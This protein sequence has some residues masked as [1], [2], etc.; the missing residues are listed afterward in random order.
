MRWLKKNGGVKKSGGKK[1]W[2]EKKCGKRLR[3]IKKSSIVK[4]LPKHNY[5]RPLKN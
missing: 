4:F 2:G 1:R 5:Y 3:R